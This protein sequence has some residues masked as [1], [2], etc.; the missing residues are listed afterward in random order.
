MNLQQ[1]KLFFNFRQLNFTY[2]SNLSIKKIILINIYYTENLTLIYVLLLVQNRR[3]QQFKL[4]LKSSSIMERIFSSRA[5][6]SAA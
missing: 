3:K 1:K 4:T 5:G 6:A 2:S